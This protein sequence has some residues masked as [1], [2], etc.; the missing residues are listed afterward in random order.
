M[1]QAKLRDGQTV[2]LSRPGAGWPAHPPACPSPGHPGPTLV[3]NLH[4]KHC[5]LLTHSQGAKHPLQTLCMAYYFFDS[6]TSPPVYRLLL[7]TEPSEPWVRYYG[8]VCHR[9]THSCLGDFLMLLWQGG[10]VSKTRLT[11]FYL[12]LSIH[13]SSFFVGLPVY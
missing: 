9:L 6:L 3:P 1:T 11:Q 8:S 12:P 10:N 5:V 2:T 7:L 13:L 4:V